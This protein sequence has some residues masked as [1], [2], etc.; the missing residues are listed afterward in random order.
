[1][2][3]KNPYTKAHLFVAAIRI[4]EHQQVAPPSLEAVCGLLSI[5]LE[6]GNRLCRKLLDLEAIGVVEKTGDTRLF[7]RDHLRLEEIPLSNAPASIADELMRFKKE[8]EAGRKSLETIRAQ[9]EEK[10]KKLQEALAQK[11]KEGLKPS[12]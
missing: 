8:K 12:V 10:K 9:Q 11:L 3:D 5:S 6:E 2:E 1:M 4:L 7:I